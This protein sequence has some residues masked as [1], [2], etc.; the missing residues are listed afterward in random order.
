MFFSVTQNLKKLNSFNIK[1]FEISES[2]NKY[3]LK[4]NLYPDN[5][6]EIPDQNHLHYEY[7]GTTHDQIFTALNND[8]HITK[9]MPNKYHFVFTQECFQEIFDYIN[10]FDAG[11]KFTDYQLKVVDILLEQ[12]FEVT[13]HFS[14]DDRDSENNPSDNVRSSKQQSMFYKFSNDKIKVNFQDNGGIYV[15]GENDINPDCGYYHPLYKAN[16]KYIMK[17]FE[18]GKIDIGTRHEVFLKFLETNKDI[19]NGRI[20]EDMD[21][22][23]DYKV[24]NKKYDGRLEKIMTFSYF[25]L[26]NRGIDIE[27]LLSQLLCCEFK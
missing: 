17:F 6:I 22:S 19:I 10:L 2:D 15:S 16:R 1:N 11:F 25:D 5:N 18:T 23:C 9:F 20:I 4:V 7:I 3:C 24:Y 21:K 12:D 14:N 13:Y 27:S 8:F 26:S